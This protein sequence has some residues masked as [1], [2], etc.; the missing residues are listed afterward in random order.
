MLADEE[1][2]Q[3]LILLRGSKRKS[4]MEDVIN[5]DSIDIHAEVFD[6]DFDEVAWDPIEID[7]SDEEAA[8]T[9]GY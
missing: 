6:K 5:D 9:Y 2:M 8:E 7:D 4:N 1:L 3:V